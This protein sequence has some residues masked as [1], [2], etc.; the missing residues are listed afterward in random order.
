[1]LNLLNFFV[2]QWFFVR[3]IRV[4]VPLCKK[5][6]EC[7]L[8]E[9]MMFVQLASDRPKTVTY[10]PGLY[11]LLTIGFVEYQWVR[12]VPLTGWVGKLWTF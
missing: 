12:A 11:E 9:Y 5:Y 10:P 3:R 2:Y 6:Q 1:M 8:A 7:S 4:L